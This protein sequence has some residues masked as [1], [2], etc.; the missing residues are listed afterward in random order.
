MTVVYFIFKINKDL[1]PILYTLKELKTRT[2][3]GSKL[4]NVTIGLFPLALCVMEPRRWS[5]LKAL[6]PTQ[7]SEMMITTVVGRG[8]PT[9]T[10]G[11]Y[12]HTQLC[13]PLRPSVCFSCGC[14]VGLKWLKWQ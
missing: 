13:E 7:S 12:N 3:R 14:F 10:T 4:S 1:N 5:E 11:L 2:E 6:Q 9:T 8:T